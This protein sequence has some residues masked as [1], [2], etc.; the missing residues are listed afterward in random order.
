MS[1]HV[2]Q[3]AFPHLFSPFQLGSMRLKNRIFVPSHGT[4]HARNHQVSDE[5]MA[6]YEARAQG[7][8]GMIFTE[9][10]SVHASYD[11]PN[12]ISLTRDE[13]IPGIKRLADMCHSHDCA[14]VVQLYHPGRIP[15]QSIDGSR[16]VAYAP[17]EVMDEQHRFQ[18]YP[19]PTD[20]VSEVAE[21]FAEAARR[22]FEAG[23][24]GIEII[25]SMGYLVAQFL[26]PRTNLRRDEYGGSLDGRLKFLR[27][28][29]AESRRRTSSTFLIGV[30]I[31]AD[32]MDHDG[33]RPKEIHEIC[34]ALDED[35]QIGFL[36]IIAGSAASVA[37]WIHVVPPMFVKHGYLAASARAIKEQVQVPVFVAGRINQPQVAEQIIENGDADLC[38]M[39]RAT[40]CDPEF[41]NKAREGR[42]E[43]I[44]ACI[45]CNQ[46]CIGHGLGEFGISCIQRPETGRELL[47]GVRQPATPIREVLVIGGGPAGL[48]A[49]AVAAER[50][51]RVTLCERDP[52]LGGQILL[53]QSLPGR[54]EFGGIIT[55]LSRECE[56]AGVTLQ[57]N[58]PVTVE[59]A[60]ASRAEIVILAT[61]AVPTE[62]NIEG[63]EE[64]NIVDAWSVINETTEVG[65]SVVIADARCDWIGLGV[66]EKLARAGCS[67]RLVVNGAVPG[68]GI[69]FVTRNMWI[70]TLHQLGVEMIPFARLFGIDDQHAYFQHTVN[71]DPMVLDDVDTVVT[72]SP[73]QRVECLAT[74]L[75]HTGQEIHL[76][77]DC[78][79][80]RTAEEAVLD[81]LRIGA[82]I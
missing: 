2:S 1:T 76:I 63:A 4:R 26:N 33:L 27:D 18:P 6:Y 9:V 16:L 82:A 74:E 24:D 5:L 10:C 44:R 56:L 48:K 40:I 80:P 71:S 31:S 20:L 69:H 58:T 78:L 34:R 36:D 22:A 35:G 28:I 81:G 75:S 12:R 13:Y 38:G 46:A 43:D 17:S 72:V 32:E 70:G 3:T 14:I 25:G 73:N 37:G 79:S 23:C 15:S 54:A 8:V 59:T 49:A 68:D 29:I 65:G 42:T 21:S 61:G 55:N 39:V 41:A 77:G 7:G 52:Y 11:M 45:G 19:M 30:R 53:A 60:D 50:G 64:G 67:V 51:H 66:A 47:Y 57:T 62:A